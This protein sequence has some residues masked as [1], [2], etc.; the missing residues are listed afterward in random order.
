MPEVEEG[1]VGNRKCIKHYTCSDKKIKQV[2]ITAGNKGRQFKS[3]RID[4]E[5]WKTGE[6]GAIKKFYRGDLVLNPKRW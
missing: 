2:G 6:R 4:N 3:P 1:P 5:K